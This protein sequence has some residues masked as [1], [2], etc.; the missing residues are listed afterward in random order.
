MAFFAFSTSARVVWMLEQF[1]PNDKSIATAAGLAA[2]ANN[3]PQTACGPVFPAAFTCPPS[4]QCL[5]LNSSASVKS[6]LCCPAGQDCRVVQPVSCNRDLQNATLYQGGQCAAA[7][8]PVPAAA[9][10]GTPASSVASSTTPG[11]TV[12]TTTSPSSSSSP[13][14][15]DAAALAAGVGSG[16]HSKFSGSSLAIGLIT[17]IFLGAIIAGL[18]FWILARRARSRVSYANEKQSPRDTLTDLTTISRRPTLHGRSISEPIAH[19]DADGRTEFLR[20][21][22]PRFPDGTGVNMGYS[23]EVQASGTAP[24]T[25]ARTPKAVKALFSRSPFMTQTPASPASTQPPLPA[26]LKR[27]TLSFAVSPARALKKQKSMH[28]LRRQ[29]TDTSRSGNWRTRPD[30][31]RSGSQETIQVLMPSNEPY[32]PDQRPQPRS[33]AP[34]TLE[35]TVYQPHDSV[36][37]W[38]TTDTPQAAMSKPTPAQYAS[39]SRYPTETFTLTRLR[40]HNAN[41]NGANNASLGTPYTPSRY[42]ANGNGPVKDVLL[43]SDGGLRVVREPEKR[44]T[45]FSAMMERAGFRKSELD[46]GTQSR[47]PEYAVHNPRTR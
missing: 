16:S 3:D 44:D 20:T 11:A 18:L 8:A 40:A 27:G 6:V 7:S 14:A 24:R 2:R 29:M 34:A 1:D 4:T 46:L 19:P 45:T 5:A 12:P 15:T 32:T 28:S 17:G 33:E 31:S 13:T 37:S 10:V 9:I 43:S 26:H 21:T 23:V 47:R 35:S 22:P 39:S 42:Y 41:I 38:R 30:G 36:T 25:P